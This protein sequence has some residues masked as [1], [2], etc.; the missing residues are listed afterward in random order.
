MRPPVCWPSRSRSSSGRD[1]FGYLALT[2][3]LLVAV[4]HYLGD[5]AEAERSMERYRAA[6]GEREIIIQLPYHARVEA[7]WPPRVPATPR[8]LSALLEA[9][10]RC[11]EMP[12]FAI[13]LRYHAMR[14]GASP[15]PLVEAVTRLRAG[16]DGRL[17][18]GLRRSHHGARRP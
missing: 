18:G 14:D 12:H 6:L 9:A 10:E 11:E 5:I 4:N 16:C 1:P 7:S 2:H 15:R 3:G 13:D 8:R 17:C